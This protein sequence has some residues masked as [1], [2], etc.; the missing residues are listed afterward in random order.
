MASQSPAGPARAQ[1]SGTPALAQAVQVQRHAVG[2]G[3][4]VVLPYERDR[5]VGLL[6][7]EVRQDRPGLVRPPEMAE[8]DRQGGV[9]R[10]L[11]VGLADGR[12]PQRV[13]GHRV[14]GK[15]KGRA[16]GTPPPSR[17]QGRWS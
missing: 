7:A 3:D 8:R 15:D 16:D 1:A 17:P 12:A 14:I 10:P 4:Q 9:A 13:F 2:V 5:E 11:E 6:G